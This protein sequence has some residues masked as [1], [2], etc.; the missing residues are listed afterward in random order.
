MNEK[1]IFVIVTYKPNKKAL[2]ELGKEL[3]DWPVVVV[4][5]TKNNRGYSGGANSGIRSALAEG[6]QWVV[7]LNQDVTITKQGI[8][9]FVKTLEK[10]SPG[11]YGPDAGTLDSTRW[12]TILPY[13]S[14]VDYISG[15][16]MAIHQKVLEK[17][18]GFYELYFMY[19]ED[20]DLCMRA[21]KAGFAIQK[22]PMKG[23]VHKEKPVFEKGSFYQEYYLAR[24]HLLFVERNAPTFVK[25]HE[26]LWMPLTLYEHYKNGNV[27]A[28][29]GIKDFALRKFYDYRH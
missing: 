4:D 1:I 23:F 9:Q 7:V 26:F 19:Y 3:G 6:A 13:K 14:S 12:S 2:E 16:C 20:A 21:K 18:G 24:N 22:I 29:T 11:V 5:N 15:S 17:I 8:T 25:V 10:L 28:L 27:G